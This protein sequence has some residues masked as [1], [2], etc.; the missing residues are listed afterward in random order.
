M[1]NVI[2]LN[3]SV[4]S[5]TSEAIQNI[6]LFSTAG[7]RRF[8]PPRHRLPC[9]GD[10]VA[11]LGLHLE[12]V[13]PDAVQPPE[14]LVGG[15]GQPGGAGAGRPVQQVCPRLPVPRSDAALWG[16]GMDPRTRQKKTRQW[17]KN[18]QNGE[19]KTKKPNKKHE[20][21]TKKAKRKKMPKSK[22]KKA[23]KNVIK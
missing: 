13:L 12:V 3:S 16:G 9:A 14:G 11:L 20:Q 6:H 22:K 2:L 15:G 17:Q 1:L 19:T 18:Q 4:L 10:G 23:W 7:N 21:E 5:T 8:A